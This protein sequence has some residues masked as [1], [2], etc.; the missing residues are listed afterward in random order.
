MKA[1]GK[2]IVIEKIEEQIT[3]E[4]GLLLSNTDA[5]AFRYQ[6]GKIILPGSDVIHL[7]ENDIIYYD[8]R[9]SYT[10]VING[11]MVTIIQERDVVVVE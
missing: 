9:N 3:T 5:K 2:N 10:L 1:I 6:K 7:K 11:E 4:S 8:T